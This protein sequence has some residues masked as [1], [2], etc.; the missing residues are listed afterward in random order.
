MAITEQTANLRNLLEVESAL[1]PSVVEY[2]MVSIGCC[3]IADF[4]NLFTESDYQDQVKLQI[5]DQTDKKGNVLQL[6]HLR[7]AWRLGSAQFPAATTRVG[8]SEPGDDEDLENRSRRRSTT[9]R[10]RQA[11]KCTCP[12]SHQF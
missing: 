8:K 3:S 5:L 2:I 7:K 4:A 1:A 9:R 11:R 10:S 12:S 6:S